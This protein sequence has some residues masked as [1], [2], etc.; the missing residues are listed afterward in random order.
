MTATPCS[1]PSS[2][3]SL[4]SSSV[5]NRDSKSS[6]ITTVSQSNG[7]SSFPFSFRDSDRQ[8]YYP[9]HELDPLRNCAPLFSSREVRVRTEPPAADPVPPRTSV[10]VQV[11]TEPPPAVRVPRRASVAVQLDTHPENKRIGVGT[12]T[13]E[14]M[15]QLRKLY[16]TLDEMNSSIHKLRAA[17]DRLRK[18]VDE[19]P[20]NV[21]EMNGSLDRRFGLRSQRQRRGK[22][23]N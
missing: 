22:R 11:R 6:P 5:R 19:P 20:P 1:A 12:Q 16:S 14:E 8:P 3:V 13:F 4:I 7:G 9:A 15:S 23:Q 10:A 17:V 18:A 2:L 21:D